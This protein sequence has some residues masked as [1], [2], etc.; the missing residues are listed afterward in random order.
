MGRDL[1][2]LV[3]DYDSGHTALNLTSLHLA[4]CDDLFGEVDSIG[5]ERV[6]PQFSSRWAESEEGGYANRNLQE[7]C[8]GNS[9]CWV[10]AEALLK[11]QL[12]SR[13]Q[14]DPANRAAWA[15]LAELEPPMKVALFWH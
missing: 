13:V 7:D 10:H 15:Y 1:T 5:G 3:F 8:H 14:D 12:H 2:L 4:R 11:L 6:P 9:L